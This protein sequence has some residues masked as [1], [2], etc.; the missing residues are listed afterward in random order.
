MT[1][2]LPAA[3]TKSNARKSC[4]AWLSPCMIV[5]PQSLKLPHS[6]GLLI[7]RMLNMMFS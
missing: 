3:F 4:V 6:F 2:A 7:N 1:I 5:V